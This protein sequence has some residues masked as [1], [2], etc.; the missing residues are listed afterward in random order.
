MYSYRISSSIPLRILVTLA[1]FA[2]DVAGI[3]FDETRRRPRRVILQHHHDASTHPAMPAPIFSSTRRGG[4]RGRQGARHGSMRP[5]CPVV[6]ARQ[7]R[8]GAAPL[9]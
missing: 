6:G 5:K 8:A 9:P 7:T 1:F 4:E 3:D 2:F